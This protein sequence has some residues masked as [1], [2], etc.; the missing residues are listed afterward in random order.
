[1]KIL[2]Q[3]TIDGEPSG[4]WHLCSRRLSGWEQEIELDFSS[5]EA[6]LVF[7]DENGIAIEDDSAQL[8]KSGE[9]R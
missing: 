1:M 2:E 9:Q 3:R 5:Y 4:V 6:A 7:A 8:A